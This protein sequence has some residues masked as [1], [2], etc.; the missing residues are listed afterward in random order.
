MIDS[1]C[2]NYIPHCIK[3]NPVN[4]VCDECESIQN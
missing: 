2:I 1:K 4:K 3:Y